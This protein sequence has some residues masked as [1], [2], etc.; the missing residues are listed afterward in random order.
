MTTVAEIVENGEVVASLPVD[1]NAGGDVDI[2]LEG[3]IRRDVSSVVVVD[4]DG[5]LRARLTPWGTEVRL[6]RGFVYKD[7]TREDCP[8]GLFRVTSSTPGYGYVGIDGSDR[9]H[10]AQA[11]SGAP[12]AV[13][14]GLTIDEACRRLVAARVPFAPFNGVQS[15][16]L[17]PPL[18]LEYGADFWDQAQQ[19]AASGGYDLAFDATGAAVL[20]PATVYLD[21][22]LRYAEDENATAFEVARALSSDRVPNGIIVQGENSHSDSPVLGQAWDMDPTSPT[23]RYGPYGEV[24]EVVRGEKVLTNL[25]AEA[26]ARGILALRL[27]RA[28]Q[29]SFDA[30][31]N[32]AHDVGDVIE[33]VRPRLGLAGLYVIDSLSVPFQLGGAMK[34]TARRYIP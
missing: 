9:A 12:L 14:G 1:T 34:V 13:P 17:T 28:E 20:R 27:G 32:P 24:A 15:E 26:S 16:W 7:G 29:V 25:Q 8:M 10:L 5:A 3:A 23:Y 30:V 19:L 31:P 2:D 22:V 6:R 33:V 11:P 4:H 18:Y 21:R